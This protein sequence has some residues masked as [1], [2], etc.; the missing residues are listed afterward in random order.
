MPSKTVATVV[1]MGGTSKGFYIITTSLSLATGG[2]LGPLEPAKTFKVL[3][4]AG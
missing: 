1:A 4:L 2:K 3:Y